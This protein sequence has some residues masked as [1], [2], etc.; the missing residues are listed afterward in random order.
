MQELGKLDSH[1]RVPCLQWVDNGWAVTLQV[2][3]AL[4]CLC[5]G[6]CYPCSPSCSSNRLTLPGSC[7]PALAA[8]TN[9]SSELTKPMLVASLSHLPQAPP[10]TLPVSPGMDQLGQS[11]MCHNTTT[12]LLCFAKTR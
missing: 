7:I 3:A 11:N 8:S 10:G 9:R 1:R 6:S 12:S 2:V 4:G 5:K